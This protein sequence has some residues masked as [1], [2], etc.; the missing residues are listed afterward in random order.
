MTRTMYTQ[1]IRE[2]DNSDCNP[3]IPGSREMRKN[4][5]GIQIFISRDFPGNAVFG[6]LGVWKEFI[7]I[8]RRSETLCAQG[9]LF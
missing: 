5:P 1:M 2:V 9:E 6:Y 7:S 8:F 3:G 4:P